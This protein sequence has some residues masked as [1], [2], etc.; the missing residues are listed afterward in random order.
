MTTAV[1]VAIVVASVGFIVQSVMF[2]RWAGKVQTLVEGH[3]REIAS[4]R[5]WR[6]NKADPAIRYQDYLKERVE[7]LERYEEEDR[8]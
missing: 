5:E 1:I 8:Q 3:D 2:G 4:F 7:K 6:H